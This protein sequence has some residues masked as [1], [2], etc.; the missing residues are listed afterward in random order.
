MDTSKKMAW[1]DDKVIILFD[2]VCNLCNG[3]VNW[4]IARDKK[5]LFRFVSLQS[6]LGQKITHHIGVDTSRIDSIIFYQPGLAYYYKSDAALKTASLLGFPWSLWGVFRVLPRP[7][8]DT[9]Y[10]WVAR[11]RYRWFGR[12]EQCRVPTPEL[13]GKFL[14]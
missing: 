10:D 11:N 5:D 8:R 13:R 9:L 1:P 7:L 14:E 12:K 6:G 2:G 3:A 4:L